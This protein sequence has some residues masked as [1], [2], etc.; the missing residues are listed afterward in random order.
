VRAGRGGELTGSNPTG[1]AKRGTKYHVVV[2]TDG[3]PLAA[4]LPP[5]T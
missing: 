2:A 5:P 1:R 4:C 3:L